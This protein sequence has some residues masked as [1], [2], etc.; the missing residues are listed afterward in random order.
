[1]ILV[2]ALL[3][4]AL[5]GSPAAN[6]QGAFDTSGFGQAGGIDF[7][8]LSDLQDEPVEFT[9]KYFASGQSGQLEI[10]AVLGRSWHIYSTTQPSGGPIRTSM[11]VQ[12][13]DSVSISGPFQPDKPPTKSVSDIYPGVTIE[14]HEDVVLWSAPIKVAE[15][16]RGD[17]KIKLSALVCQNGGSCMPADKVLTAKW[18]GPAE[19]DA[20]KVLTA[21]AQSDA[22]KPSKAKTASQLLS[23]A[24]AKTTTFRDNDYEVT[25]TAGVS[26]AIAPGAQGQLLFR[27]KPA[28]D[29]HV[30][31]GVVD[32]SESSTNFVV[33]QKSGL[34]VG[35]P[36]ADQPI[37]SKSLLP[38]IP[39]LPPTP[40]V[41]YHSG[42]VT[43]S[44]PVK[45]P[46]ETKPGEYELQGYVCYQACTDKACLQPMAM[47]FAAKV[48]V[49]EKTNE[50]VK[51]LEIKSVKYVT[52]IDKAAETDWV[53]ALMPDSDT[54][55]DNTTP[56]RSISP[57]RSGS[58]PADPTG[59]SEDADG[60]DSPAVIAATSNGQVDGPDSPAASMSLPLILLM[61]LGGGLILNLMP[62]V[63]PVVGLKIMS[64][65]QQAGEDR[66]QIFFLNLAYV[67]GILAVFAILA[68][69]AAVFSFGWGEQFAYF[70][71]RISLTVV[72]FALA[73]SYL[74][75][76]ELPTPGIATGQSSNELQSKE[77]MTGAFFT[78][79]F[80][81]VLATPCSGPLLGVALGYTIYLNTVETVAVIMTV[82]LGMSLPY[83]LLGLFPQAVGILPKPGNWMVTLKEF[84]AFLFLGTVAFFFNQFSDG[85]KLPVFVTLVG[86][87]FGCWVIGKVPPWETLPKRLRGWSFGI[88][89]AAAIGWLAFVYLERAP[90][91]IPDGN[92]VQYIVER[93]VRWERYNE[94]RLQQYR[95]EGKTVMLDFT[96]KWCPNCITN[97][98]VALDT[99]PTSKMLAELDCVAMLADYTNLDDP[100]K[101][102]LRELGSNSIPMLV[103]YPGSRPDEPI[104]LRDLVSQSRVLNALKEAGPSVDGEQVVSHSGSYQRLTSATAADRDTTAAQNH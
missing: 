80:A 26:S 4:F 7:G 74:G 92:G 84:L 32:D 59:P 51:P 64:F 73:L 79:A 34:L 67:G 42:Q 47:Q 16:F 88:A 87:W 53:D 66:K 101:S 1:M 68:M 45:V 61:A 36:L 6:G 58:L 28:G 31:Q 25:W 8:A 81:T 9:A 46:A 40:P 20:E 65:V 72:I 102:K 103:I 52:A 22:E 38:N 55:S 23:D 104:L 41:K 90:D 60:D 19:E 78:G 69:L 39:G 50:T 83:I 91:P 29:F 44:L 100:I 76:W 17:I 96:A 99:K 71:V 97:T 54:L 35:E 10:E 43:W 86:V 85:Q 30:Y 93:H 98:L 70:S 95:A 48:V 56:S 14:E 89:S 49:A 37:I 15:G 13:P 33:T 2:A 11:Q 3:G 12:S 27:A 18:A 75:V 21:T 82:G 94:E 62:C 24:A 57:S 5:T 63:L 77:G